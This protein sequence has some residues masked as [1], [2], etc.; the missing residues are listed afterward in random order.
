[1]LQHACIASHRPHMP[2]VI[3]LFNISAPLLSTETNISVGDGDDNDDDDDNGSGGGRERERDKKKKKNRRVSLL[4]CVLTVVLW[5][6]AA[7]FNITENVLYMYT[8]AINSKNGAMHGMAHRQL[9]RLDA[10]A[11]HARHAGYSN[12]KNYA[13]CCCGDVYG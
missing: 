11:R 13:L 6:L 3:T 8:R 12:H 7:A 10:R 9:V 4:F 1:M 2:N 5:L